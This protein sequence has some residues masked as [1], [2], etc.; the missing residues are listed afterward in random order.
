MDYIKDNKAAWEEAFEHRHQGWGDE[1]YKILLNERLPFFCPDV[2]EALQ[3]MDFKDKHI[4]Q[5]CCNNGRELLSL[6]QLGAKS[7]TGF[8]IAENI[9]KQAEYTAQKAGISN[10]RFHACNILDIDQRYSNRFDFILF[11]IGAVTWFKDLNPLFRK[12]SDCLK[13]NGTLLIHDFHP[14]MNMLPMPGEPEFDGQDLNRITYSYFRNEPWIENEGMGYMSEQY[15][16][17]TFTSFSHTISDIINAISGSQMR[18]VR[19]DE[20]DYDVGLS[21]VYDGKGFP[22]SYLLKAEK[23]FSKKPS[24]LMLK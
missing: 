23:A 8:D 16:S 4:A 12:V 3:A 21:D 13:P 10:C 9:I 20:F 15:H 14:V 17:K 2:A 5:F 18:I 6:M 24:R 1:N 7:G 19:F 22:L 11:T